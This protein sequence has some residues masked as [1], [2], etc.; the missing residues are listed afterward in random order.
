VLSWYY[1]VA[2]LL[3][4]GN[5]VE[6]LNFVVVAVALVVVVVVVSFAAARL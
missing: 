2:C 4:W 1:A 3:N 6:I 5:I